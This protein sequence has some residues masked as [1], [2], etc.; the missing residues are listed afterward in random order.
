MK[1]LHFIF[2]VLLPFCLEASLSEVAT[3]IRKNRRGTVRNYPSI[4]KH[5]VNSGLYYSSTPFIKEYLTV[6]RGGGSRSIDTQIDEVVSRVGVKQFEVLPTAFL[7]R[8]AAPM[9]RYI[10]AKKYFR[11]GQYDKALNA[12][13]GRISSGHPIK[14]FALHLEATILSIRKQYGQARE[15]FKSCV[16]SSKK[17]EGRYEDETRKKQLRINKDS[18]LAG[19]AR[20]YF[21]S[22]NFKKAE[23]AYLD[24]EK[25]SPIWPDILFEEAWNSFYK[26]NYNR[27]LGKL[28]T[29]KAPV[30]NYVYNPEI[31]ILRTLTYMELCL[32]E[33]TKKAVDDFYARYQRDTEDLDR[34]LRA[35]RKNLKQFYAMAKE[36]SA[37]DSGNEL[38]NS[39]LNSLDRDPAYQ[40]LYQ[41]FL[42][43]KK[44][45]EK[46]SRIQNVTLKRILMR[47]VTDSMTLQ[48]NL[49]GGYVRKLFSNG[50]RVIKRM[51]E[52]M[53]YIK[54]EVLSRRKTTLYGDSDEPERSRGKMQ[55]LVRSDKQYFWSFNGEFWADELGD[56]VFGLKS[57]CR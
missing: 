38:L 9:L 50:T 23:S 3:L 40:E 22:K 31:D 29:Y 56:Y 48:R 14:P 37:R 7:E 10:L 46:V 21:A 13:G 55:N 26:G 5:L 47:N 24:I 39:I 16:Y 20:N 12:V 15:K 8:S 36:K 19:V 44:E 49:I 43:G 27:T 2:F 42:D 51:F 52:S 18:C 35:N 25:S 32:W 33:D 54:L 53:S 17:F 11:R 4:I 1:L 34:I 28:V 45:I 41:S 30:L 6:N 57:E